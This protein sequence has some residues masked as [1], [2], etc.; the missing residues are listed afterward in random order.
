MLL[1]TNVFHFRAKL[2]AMGE[3]PGYVLAGKDLVKPAL[4]MHDH[5]PAGATIATRRIGAVAYY[6]RR[7][8]FDY[9]YGLTDAEVAPLVALH[10]GR[11]ESPTDPALAA[12]WR[13]RPPEYFLEDS[14][15]MDYILGLSGG[16]RE[17][18]LIHGIPYHV[19]RQ[20][21]IGHDSRWILARRRRIP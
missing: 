16:T 8:V 21:P 18:F 19:I 3:F 13:T 11:F 20:F 6:S 1:A 4:W 14:L 15:I 7:Q 10:G 17:R 12:V 5:L 2:A 9:A